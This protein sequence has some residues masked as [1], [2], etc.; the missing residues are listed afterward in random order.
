V[1]QRYPGKLSGDAGAWSN[2]I[3]AHHARLTDGLVKKLRSFVL[4]VVLSSAAWSAALELP[5]VREGDSWIYRSTTEKGP[6]GW[7]QT[8][9]EITVTRVTA[10]RIFLSVKPSGSTQ[11]PKE[12]FLGRDWSRSRD[13]NGKET[14]VNRPLSFPLSEKTT[15]ELRPGRAAPPWSPR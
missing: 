3:L 2:V 5:P 6:G 7:N 10:A 4:G 9:E 8:R 13:V 11:A 1:P 14:V 15:W 12:M